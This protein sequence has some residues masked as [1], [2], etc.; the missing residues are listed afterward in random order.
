MLGRDVHTVLQRQGVTTLHHANTV[1]TSCS[2]LQIGGLASRGYVARNGLKQTGQYSD[3]ADQKYGIWDDIFVDG[4]DIHERARIRNQYG[5]V[6]FELPVQVL[7]NLPAGTQVMVTKKNPVHWKDGEPQSDRYF[8]NMAELQA[9]YRYGE[10]GQHIIVRA[11]DGFI[12]F[13]A[14]P[15]SIVLDDPQRPMSKGQD[16]FATAEAKLQAAATVGKVAIAVRKRQCRDGCR[17]L[18]GHKNSYSIFSSLD[19]QF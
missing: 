4:V 16:A 12:P 15:V 14:G 8:E 17:C 13:G 18:S 5:P 7:Q 6:L 10:F 2:Y 19:G 3:A 1:T 9:G 11:P